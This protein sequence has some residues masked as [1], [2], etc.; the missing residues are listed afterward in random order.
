[1]RFFK[2][3][4]RSSSSSFHW[5][6]IFED[7]LSRFDWIEIGFVNLHV[8]HEIYYYDNYQYNRTL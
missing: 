7:I 2:Y 8:L 5:S 6:L 3:F 1:M 4:K